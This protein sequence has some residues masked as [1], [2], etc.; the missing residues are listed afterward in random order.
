MSPSCTA[1]N[2]REGSESEDVAMTYDLVVRGGTVVD[3]SGLPRYRS[4][5]AVAGGRI[6][7]VSRRIAERGRDEIDARD[8]VVTPGFIDGHTH[9]D[10]QVAWDPLGTCSC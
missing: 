4:D 2:V 7:R 3:S 1:S 6:A 10:A 8:L 9:M 5:V